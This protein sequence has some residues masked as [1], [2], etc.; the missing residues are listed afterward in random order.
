MPEILSSFAQENIKRAAS[1]IRAGRLV[2]FPT[3]TVYGLGADAT[4]DTAVAKIFQAKNRPDFNPLIVHYHSRDAAFADVER[5]DIALTLAR[6]FWP[7]S[8]TLV[9]KRKPDC[10]VSL[11][12]SAGLDTLAVRVPDLADAR[13][14]IRQAGTPLAAPSANRSCGISPTSAEHVASSLDNNVELI[15]DGGA[16]KAGLESTVIGFFNSQPHILRHGA[17]AREKIE[18]EL[19]LKL[20]D[21]TAVADNQAHH[22]PGQMLKHYAPDIPIRL[23]ALHIKPGEALIA[24]GSNVPAGAEKTVNL[25]PS[26][27]LAEAAANLFKTMHLLNSNKYEGIAVM[28]IPEYGLGIAINDRLRRA[29]STAV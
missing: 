11:L 6:K 22:S 1:L 12:C 14:F 3:E 10:R 13:E 4:S 28:P 15:L 5:N 29:S 9:L 25:S 17:I 2:A 20:T 24:F 8:L 27:D 26:G 7:G 19:K 16:C 18:E 21:L 23:N